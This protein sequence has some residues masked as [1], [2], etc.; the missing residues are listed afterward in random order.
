MAQDQAESPGVTLHGSIW[1]YSGSDGSLLWK[2]DGP[3]SSYRLGH[4]VAIAGDMN[5]D[6]FEDVVAS[7]LGTATNGGIVYAF[8]GV[9]GTL[10]WETQEPAT[11]R[12]GHHI[13]RL[14]DL[15]QDGFADA[16]VGAPYTNRG[17]DLHV[18]ETFILSGNDASVLW[19]KQGANA[20]DYFG[21][22]VAGCGH[23]DQDQI[24]DFIVG[25]HKADPNGN[26]N[27]GSAFV[28]SGAS[29][30]QIY[31]LN[32]E[33]QA[34]EFGRSVAYAGD[35]NGDGHDDLLA[36]T[37]LTDQPGILSSGT[38]YLYSGKDG[39][40]LWRKNGTVEWSGLGEALAGGDINADG[41]PDLLSTAPGMPGPGFQDE[42]EAYVDAFLPYLSVS[43]RFPSASSGGTIDLRLDFPVTEAYQPFALLASATG[44]GPIEVQGVEIFLSPDFLFL[45]FIH[46]NPPPGFTQSQGNLDAAGD[47]ISQYVYQA[48][49]SALVGRTFFLSAVSYAPPQ[50]RRL[51]SASVSITVRP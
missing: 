5:G 12:F 47:G 14:G 4:S 16:L 50:S 22:S 26:L 32:G 2:T 31:R 34:D 20:F 27:A 39:T 3:G 21:F 38:A 19:S 30:S 45:Q 13:A 23:V 46:G 41:Y 6:G 25:S 24:V 8:S 35:V 48:G 43:D 49:G 36:G 11:A 17:S 51:A 29:G 28:F 42:G 1:V 44:T 18:G 15:N 9:N 10:L 40:L 7:A 33:V 37:Q